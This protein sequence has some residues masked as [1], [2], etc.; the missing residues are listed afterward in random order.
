VQSGYRSDSNDCGGSE[1]SGQSKPNQTA[2]QRGP[3]RRWR[4]QRKRSDRWDL[5]ARGDYRTNTGECSCTHLG[6][7]PSLDSARVEERR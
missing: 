5:P 2:A 4:R 6:R 7:R 1:R 3:R